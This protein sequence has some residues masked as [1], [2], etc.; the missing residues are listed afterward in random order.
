MSSHLLKFYTPKMQPG[1]YALELSFNN[2]EYLPY[3]DLI[4]RFSHQVTLFSS[5]PTFGANN[6]GTNVYLY[7]TNF[8]FSEDLGC[9]FGS[10]TIIPALVSYFIYI[11]FLDNW[12]STM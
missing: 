12:Q 11:L 1:E 8:V 4:F 3:D 2:H 6:G 5:F 9:V 7:G 10:S